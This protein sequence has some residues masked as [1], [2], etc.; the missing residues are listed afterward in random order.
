MELRRAKIPYMLMGGMSFYDRKEVR[1]VLAYLK[2]L[3]HP[4][5][6]VSLLRIINTPAARHRPEPR[7]SVWS[8][9]AVAP[10]QA[11]LGDVAG[12]LTG[13][14]SRR[15][16]VSSLIERS[17]QSAETGRCAESGSD[18]DPRGGLSRGTRPAVSRHRASSRPA[19]RPVEEVVNA[20]A[21]YCQRRRSRRWP[22]SCR[23]WP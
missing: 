1:D 23:T 13:A 9:R 14:A 22:A 2:M 12:R 15:S 16:N 18:A 7:S 17:R 10:R 19:G 5:D 3:A 20:V 8:K 4:A 21:V 6:E 11:A